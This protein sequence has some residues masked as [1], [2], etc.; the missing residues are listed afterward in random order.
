MLR[1]RGSK[2][3]AVVC[4]F[5]LLSLAGGCGHS[6]KTVLRC[7]G[8]GDTEEARI[9]QAIV[10]DFQK[11]HPG[12]EVRFERAPYGE[13]ITKVLTLFSAGSA[14]D[15]MAVN[16]EQMVAFASRGALLDLGPY[17]D[18]DPSIQMKDFYPEAIRH[19]TY[20]GALTALPRDIAPVACIYYNKKAFD[21]AGL[22]YP[23]ND[24]D[25]QQFLADAQK[26]TLKDDQGNIKRFGFVDEWTA[27]DAWVYAFG[28][29]LVDDL[30]HPTRCTL[31]SPRAAA[32]V[33]FRGDLMTKY[34]VSPSPSNLTA[35][36][37]MG[38][39]DMFVNKTAAMF[40][41]GIWRTPQFRE[42]KDFDW[43]VVEFP[44][45]PHGH[46]GFPLSAAGYGI[47]KGTKNADLAYELVKYLAGE[48]GQRY[49][50]ATGLTQPALKTLAKSPVF[51]DGKPPKSKGFLVDAVKDGTFQ[52]VDPN[53]NEWYNSWAVPALDKVWSG[54]ETAARVLSE[55]TASIN[56]K[57]YKK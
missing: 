1:D 19:Y 46:R 55:L 45:G 57:F 9:L 3:L 48:V 25:Y 28:G 52:P 22:P 39:S 47:V 38:S 31:D 40:F 12:V 10:G 26:L 36:G 32:G 5:F 2:F 13:Y 41:S 20:R 7:T 54:K 11:A 15:V 33:Q 24:W 30:D 53:I 8:W 37:A 6:N 56:R 27:W 14:P 49:M 16:A 50:A 23:K 44:K 51:L 18:K 4:S 21:E 29:S 34:H 17:V 42:I 35:M 43:D